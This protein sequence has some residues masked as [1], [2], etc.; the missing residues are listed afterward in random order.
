MKQS[1][2]D[3][4]IIHENE[5]STLVPMELF[6]EE[7]LADYLK[8]NSKILKSDFI[9]YDTVSANNSVNVY[10][11]YVNINNFIYEKFGTFTYRHFSTILIETLLK[12]EME[13]SETVM[14]VNVAS[15]HFEI[16]TFKYGELVYYN[17]F[18]YNTKEDFIYYILFATEQLQLNPETLNLKFLGA[19]S[20][21]ND[22]YEIA[23]KYIRHVDFGKRLNT[24]KYQ[25]EP[26]TSNS[27]FTLTHSF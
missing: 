15:S 6:K 22:L 9:S 5:L 20:K 16:V 18:E 3:V 7:N 11:P 8:F 24:F 10:V 27:D 19:I 4:H 13:S 1:F 14:Y 23:Y 26:L 21:E 17:T 12:T 25:N 2:Q